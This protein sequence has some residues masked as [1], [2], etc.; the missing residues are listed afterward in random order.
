LALAV[1]ALVVLAGALAPGAQARTSGFQRLAPSS[2]PLTAVAADPT[3]GLIYAQENVGTRFFVYDPRTNVWRELAEAPLNSDN[4][5]GAAYLGGKIYAAYTGNAA[6]MGVYDIASNSWT[7]IENP[8]ERG[9]ADITAGNGKLYLAV[10]REFFEYDPAT[11]IFTPLAAPTEFT[12]PGCVEGFD[13]WGGLQFDGSKIYGHQGDA[14]NGFAV[15]DIPTNTWSDLPMISDVKNAGAVAGSGF[16]PVT[17]TYLAYGPYN[18][19]T[20]FR[21]DVEAG[22]WSTTPTPFDVNDGGMAYIA[23][24]GHE[25]VYIIQGQNGTEFTR[26]TEQNETDLAA[27]ISTNVSPLA[28]GARLT[29][30]VRVKDE[31]PERASGVVLSD[32]LPAGAKLLS[33]AGSQASCTGT[34]TLSCSLGVLRSGETAT[35]TIEVQVSVGAA[36]DTA[37]VSSQALDA[38]PANDSAMAVTKVFACVVPKLKGLGLKKAKKALRKAHC[39]PGKVKHRNSDKVKKGRVIRGGKHGGTKLPAGSK[40]DLAVS[41]GAKHEKRGGH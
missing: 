26:Y 4:N 9:T 13:P 5:G 17:N 34:S 23:L 11:G 21:Y 37:T 22:S 31:G 33:A 32:Q 10:N 16:D 27:A 7:V 36:V 14:C 1:I 38:N 6:E 30:S 15:Y 19:A 25:G 41:S 3:T 35:L 39:R 12:P 8:L 40:V 2:V 18:R 28:S 24:A 20:L 29:Y